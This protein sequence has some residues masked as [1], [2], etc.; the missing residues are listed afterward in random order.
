MMERAEVLTLV[1]QSD[2]C[3]VTSEG[4]VKCWGYN[5]FG[6]VTHHL[7]QFLLLL[8]SAW[9]AVWLQQPRAAD[10]VDVCSLEI[11]QPQLVQLPFLLL[12]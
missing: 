2:S 4:G 9:R 1:M 6:Q 7:L 8:I 11:T 12:D 3:A 10:G 5:Y